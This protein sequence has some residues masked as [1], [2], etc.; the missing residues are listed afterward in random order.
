ELYQ[1]SLLAEYAAC[2]VLPFVFAFIDRVCE[3]RRVLDVVG[4]G[5]AYALFCLTNL[6]LAVI[7]SLA[8]LVFGL[9]RAGRKT[10]WQ[11]TPLLAAGVLAGLA[12]SAFFWVRM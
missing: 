1:A 8:A 3:R 6:P 10:F 9:V 7:G 11:A 5:V 12:A 2:A 4:L